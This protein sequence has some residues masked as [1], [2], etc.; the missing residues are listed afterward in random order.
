MNLSLAE[1][2][3][4]ESPTLNGSIPVRYVAPPSLEGPEMV[5]GV[6]RYFD[7]GNI[8]NVIRI[9]SIYFLRGYPYEHTST[10]WV[11]N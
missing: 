1:V 6:Q 7:Y 9:V 3:M 4:L 10:Q 11:L 8:Y 2:D 5:I